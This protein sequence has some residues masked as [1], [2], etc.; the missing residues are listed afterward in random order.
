MDIVELF[1]QS[2][3]WHSQAGPIAI[4]DMETN[5]IENTIAMLDRN[6]E[7]VRTRYGLALF[8]GPLQPSGDMANDALD[9]AIAEDARQSDKT[10]LHSTPLYRALKRELRKRTAKPI[11][12]I[13]DDYETIHGSM[14][15][16]AAH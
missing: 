3:T 13:D 4:R 1:S 15:D 10:W 7:D 5:H 2:K 12:V 14:A 16:H 9:S 11:P 8:A 6:V